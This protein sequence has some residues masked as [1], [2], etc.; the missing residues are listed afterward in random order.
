[1]QVVCSIGKTRC[2]HFRTSL[3][4]GREDDGFCYGVQLWRHNEE[5]YYLFYFSVRRSFAASGGGDAGKKKKKGE[6]KFGEDAPE[7]TGVSIT[8]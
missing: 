5:R 2:E 7:N 6:R 8:A 3:S 1:M 4:H